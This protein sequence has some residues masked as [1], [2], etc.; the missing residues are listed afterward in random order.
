MSESTVLLPERHPTLEL[1]V[2]DVA[3]AVLKDVMQ[4]MEHPFFSLT[5]KPDTVVRRYEHGANW[6]E[7]T[8]SVKGLATIHDKDILIY[9]IS[10]VM[11]A[12][13]RGEKVSRRIR[14]NSADLLRFTN[15]GT[16]GREYRLLVDAL[17][18]LEGTRIRTNIRTGDHAR[19]EGF[20]LI[21]ASAIER[22]FG[23]NGR[24]LWCE[25]VLSDWV[26]NAIRANEV[27]TLHRDY[28]RLRRPLERRVYEMAR[29]H[30]GTQKTWRISVDTLRKKSGSTSPIRLFRQMVRHLV[31]H[32]HLPDYSVTLEDD[33]V[34]FTN[35]NTMQPERRIA[36]VA[37][38]PVSN[39]GY[40]DARSRA[41]GWDVYYLEQEWR[42]WCAEQEIEP[43]N[44]DRHFVSFC[45]AWFE[46]RGRP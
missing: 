27:L 35:R 6:I 10:Q 15:R 8:P 32:D 45:I 12:L 7:I 19:T 13:K 2:C 40:E 9:C 17:D 39:I 30:C 26:F 34:V 28:F 1:F 36:D 24:M 18:R 41:P 38:G 25:V 22:R 20:G 31:E 23:L 14:V 29:K 46:K 21:D 11:A 43:R 42:A 33:N 44:P 3:D 16:G 5:T 37:I 4:H